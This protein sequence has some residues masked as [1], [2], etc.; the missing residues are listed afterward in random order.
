MGLTS[1]AAAG[2]E[3]RAELAVVS[4]CHL[5]DAATPAA[6]SPG[7]AEDA[8]DA[9]DVLAAALSRISPETAD[10]LAAVATATTAARRWLGL[11]ADPDRDPDS[12]G[13]GVGPCRALDHR[14]LLPP[15]RRRCPGRD[16][17]V[18]GPGTRAFARNAEPGAW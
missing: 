7:A 4:A 9:I 15:V 12:A 18:L 14:P 8:L 2:V 6:W 17:G 5:A 13:R 16:G 1:R 11:P 10:A 3:Q